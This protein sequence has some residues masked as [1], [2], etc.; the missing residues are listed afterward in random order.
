MN[1]KKAAAHVALTHNAAED[2]ANIETYSIAEWGERTALKYVADIEAALE[3]LRTHP[4]LLRPEERFHPD[5][6]FYRVNKHLLVCDVYDG[7]IIV[8][9]VI[10]ASRDIPSRLAELQPTL[11]AEVEL[12]RAQL[13]RAQQ[14]TPRQKKR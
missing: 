12:L 13:R 3:R 8:L 14:N 7:T 4:D 2:I 11:V 5:L 10:H 1:A 9:A 6:M